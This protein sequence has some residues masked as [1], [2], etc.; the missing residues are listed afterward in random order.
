MGAPPLHLR[1]SRPGS[2]AAGEQ[3]AG[4]GGRPG[5]G[6]RGAPSRV[7]RAGRAAVHGAAGHRWRRSRGPGPGRRHGRRRRP[8]LGGAAVVAAA[9]GR[10][11]GRLAC[12]VGSGRPQH[13]GLLH[14]RGGHPGPATRS[15]LSGT[16]PGGLHAGHDIVPA[17]VE[18]VGR[19]AGYLG[20]ML[21]L[22]L[23]IFAFVVLRPVLPIPVVGRS[24]AGRYRRGSLEAARTSRTLGGDPWGMLV[25]AQAGALLVGALG[26]VILGLVAAGGL[27]A[28]VV[29]YLA[30]TRSGLLVS[31]ALRGRRRRRRDD[32]RAAARGA[33]GAGGGGRRHRRAGGPAP[34]R[35]RRP[36]CGL[37][38]AGAP[39]G[40]GRPPRRRLRLACR[41]GR[42]RLACSRRRA[43]RRAAS[44]PAALLGACPGL[45][46]A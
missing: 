12:H 1:R 40:H 43:S 46:R 15:R 17:V 14:V 26:G 5:V 7:Q 36:R 44:R 6:A 2:L 41:R 20:P 4:S 28:D 35:G 29:G 42:P 39:R 9:G 45:R 23:F 11:H 19:A 8:R 24:R 31:G 10:L 18:V 16:G 34:A 3:L 22:G 33:D 13:G 32:L 25:T 30:G 27:G 38:L 21:A 37:R